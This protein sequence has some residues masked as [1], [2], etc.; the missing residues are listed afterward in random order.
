MGEILVIW[1]LLRS[2]LTDLGSKVETELD[3]FGA[4]LL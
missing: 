3:E 1:W 4:L 2:W